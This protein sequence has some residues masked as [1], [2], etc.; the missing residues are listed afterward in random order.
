MSKIEMVAS[1]QGAVPTKDPLVSRVAELTRHVM[2]LRRVL[3]D[4]SDKSDPKKANPA[5]NPFVFWYSPRTSDM[6]CHLLGNHITA[7]TMDDLLDYAE[8]KVCD[9]YNKLYE[10]SYISL[11][12][13]SYDDE[14]EKWS[15]ERLMKEYKKL[16]DKMSQN[17]IRKP[18]K[19]RVKKDESK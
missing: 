7:P 5:K 17:K 9:I 6:S 16:Q 1:A 15:Q 14:P 11:E 18:R 3:L 4:D 10:T 19:P 12:Q 13:L 8:I 2:K